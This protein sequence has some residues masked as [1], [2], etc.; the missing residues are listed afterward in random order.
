MKE[1]EIRPP[2]MMVYIHM[3]LGYCYTLQNTITSA[4]PSG[5][6]FPFGT[7]PF[8]HWKVFAKSPFQGKGFTNFNHTTRKGSY[9]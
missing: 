5:N 2:L 9:W 8:V 3:Q 6:L 7:L 1:V 4:K